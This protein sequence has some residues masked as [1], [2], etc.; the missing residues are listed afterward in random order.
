MNALPQLRNNFGPFILERPRLNRL[1]AEAM[2]YPLVLVCAGTGY[3]KTS[4]VQDFVQMYQNTTGWLQISVR[5][6]VGARFWES[7]IHTITKTNEPL[8]K[9]VSNLGF[10]DNEDKINQY[11]AI[12]H[13]RVVIK[14]R[15]IV[16]DDFHLIENQAV[17]RFIERGI[18]NMPRGASLFLISRSTP[19]INIAGLISRGLVFNISESDLRFNESELAQFF[20]QQEIHLL[21]NSLREIYQ[22]TGGWAFAI[23]LIARSYKKAPGYGGYLRSAMKM[24]I[25]SLMETEIYNEISQ[26]LQNFLIR[27][28]LIDHLSVELITLLAKG[29]DQLLA[30][31]DRQ[32][33]YV[34]RDNYINAYLIHHLFLEF[35]GQKQSLLTEGQ[36]RETYRISGDWCNKNGFKIDALAYYEKIGDYESIVAIFYELPTQVPQDIAAYAADIFSRAPPEAFGRVDLLAVMHVR[37]LIC[38]GL[39]REAFKL[40]TFYETKYLRLP[41]DSAFRNRTLGGLYYCWGIMRLLMST[42][43]DEYDFDLYFAK[44]DECL[45]RHSLD[46]GQLANHPVGPWI[47]PVGAARKGAPQESIEAL[48][49][50]VSHTAHCF[51]GAMIGADDLARGELKYYQADLRAAEPFFA[52][53]LEQAQKHR[54]FEIV[55]RSNFYLLRIAVAQGNY[56]KAEQALKDMQAQLEENDYTVRFITFDIA[57]AW[58]YCF[59]GL[60]DKVPDWLKDKFVDYGHAYFLENFGNQAK[61]RYAY[62]SNNY[63]PLLAYMQEQKRRESILF[64]RVEMQAL[65]A[66]THFKSKNKTEALAVLGEAHATASPNDI[67]MPFIAMGK[68]MRTLTTYAL[69]ETSHKI[70]QP[71]L[72]ALN[73]KSASYAK[74]QAHVIAQ[75][76]QANRLEKEVTFSPRELE[77]LTDLSHGLSRAEIAA[78]RNISINTVKMVITII[79]SKLGVE[80]LADLIRIAVERKMI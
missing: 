17:L 13:E 16:V 9:A 75:Y 39:W 4:A 29:D 57:L 41:A 32:S 79:Y 14:K 51:N 65:E 47:N 46:P 26:N 18:L 25:F 58:Y 76:K 11:H 1:F 77:I 2:Q 8:A 52:R 67:I 74:R 53:A 21:P 20:R 24:N 42:I 69:K 73:R 43:D 5:D 33:A 62:L 3:G 15:I 59:L 61:A 48:T 6:N 50:S 7:F 35:L 19:S 22:D 64:G 56:A 55:N 23:N 36:K 27:L 28:S 31:L 63:A 72:E 38:L 45:S 40:L 10:P 71:W 66:C 78:S 44:Q 60:P 34:R 49:R 12:L 37:V 68:D 80:N 70:P 30:E 54:Q